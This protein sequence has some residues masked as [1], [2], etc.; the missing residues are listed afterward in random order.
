MKDLDCVSCYYN[1]CNYWWIGLVLEKYD[2]QEDLHIQFMHF[3]WPSPSSARPFFEDICWVTNNQ[4]FCKIDIATTNTGRSFLTSKTNIINFVQSWL[5]HSSNRVIFTITL[6]KEQTFYIWM[7]IYNDYKWG[8]YLKTTTF[9]IC[10]I[11]SNI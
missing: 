5:N 6:E 7:R 9:T 11:S 3:N 2:Q 1:Y 10:M 4:I 8:T